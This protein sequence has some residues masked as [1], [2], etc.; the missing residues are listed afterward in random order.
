MQYFADFVSPG[1]AQ[2]VNGC[3]GKLESFDSQ[4]CQNFSVKVIKI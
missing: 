3:G 4:L 2:A 1:S